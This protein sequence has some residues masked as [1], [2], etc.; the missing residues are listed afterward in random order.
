MGSAIRALLRG[1]SHR[2]RGFSR[3][4]FMSDA[5][6]ERALGERTA[7]TIRSRMSDPAD[8]FRGA[9]PGLWWLACT[10]PDERRIADP[11]DTAGKR[12]MCGKCGTSFETRLTREALDRAMDSVMKRKP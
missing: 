12:V 8:M 11:E 1:G 5:W 4:V 9:G 6:D 2:G 3:D 7:R 10:H